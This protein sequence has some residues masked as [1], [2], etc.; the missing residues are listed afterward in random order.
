M[1]KKLLVSSGTYKFLKPSD[2]YRFGDPVN[3]GERDSLH[4]EDD[5]DD[6]DDDE[7]GNDGRRGRESGSHRRDDSDEFADDEAMSNQEDSSSQE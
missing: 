4:S 3:E 6:E 7:D 1:V 5:E 2:C